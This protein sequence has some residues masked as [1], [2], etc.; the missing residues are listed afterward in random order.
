MIMDTNYIMRKASESDKDVCHSS[1]C[2]M[3]VNTSI[4]LNVKVGV[5]Y[6]SA[7][8][9]NEFAVVLS[10]MNITSMTTLRSDPFSD[11]TNTITIR[12]NSDRSTPF[13]CPAINAEYD[14][15]TK[16]VIAT[17]VIL[18]G[19]VVIGTTLDVVLWSASSRKMTSREDNKPKDH[20]SETDCSKEIKHHLLTHNKAKA[21]QD[22]PTI[23]HFILVFSLYNTIPNLLKRQSPSALKTLGAIKIFSNLIIVIYHAQQFIVLLF[24]ATIQNLYL[25]HLASKL[26]FQP[27]INANLA[28]ET[29][30]V[31][32][33]T[34]STYLTLKD[35][36]RHKR[37]RFKYF[38]LHRILRLF[39]LLFLYTII[40]Y[41]LFPHFGQGP[42]WSPFDAFACKNTW[43]YVLLYLGNT[44]YMHNGMTLTCMAVTWH[45]AADMQLFMVSP[46]FIVLLYHIWYVG[47]AAVAVT[48]VAATVTIGYVSDANGYWAAMIYNP[49]AVQQATEFYNKAYFRAN[50]Y[51]TGILL[52]YILYKKLHIAKLPIG[53]CLKWL[54]Y[55]LLWGIAIMLCTITMFWTYGAY[56]NTYQFSHSE[57]VVYLTFSGLAWSVGIAIIIYI[58]NTGYGGVVN[59]VLS[60]PGWE[61]FVKL[62]YGVTLSHMMMMLY[63]VGTLQSSLKYTDMVFTMIMVFIL[64]LSYSFSAI[65]AVFVELPV[66][67]VVFLFFRLAGMEIRSK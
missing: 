1:D 8:S 58:C 17:C 46:V 54:T 30:F 38:Y 2:P 53:S 23:K 37:F 12:L 59:S 5:C 24:P 61:P 16:A 9:A 27:V 14:A 42:A 50:S 40:A 32:S 55:A 33:A 4:V 36:E 22:H 20:I 41:K 7:C 31:V 49:Q 3:P 19:L 52:G 43:W 65:T 51:L 10:K 15:G 57:N 6:P 45:I 25:Q 35:M 13:S 62:N 67:Q 21:T 28:V 60:W 26:L 48:M 63:T 56:N 64:V 39:P 66:S 18:V 34:L 47:L 29:F 11:N 44:S